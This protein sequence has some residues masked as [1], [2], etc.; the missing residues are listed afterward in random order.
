MHCGR[1]VQC[2]SHQLTMRWFHSRPWTRLAGI[3]TLSL[4]ARDRTASNSGTLANGLTKMQAA[5]EW[6][7]APIFARSSEWKEKFVNPSMAHSTMEALATV[8][9]LDHDGKLDESPQDKETK[10]CHRLAPR[11]ITKPGRCQTRVS[12]CFQSSWASQS[13]SYGTDSAPDET[14][15]TC[16]SPWALCWFFAHPLQWSLYGTKTSC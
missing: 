9:R 12:T 13:L 6:D 4:A 10:G 5:R 14:C 16:F 2:H 15:V 7:H 3:H 1:P 11:R 8:R